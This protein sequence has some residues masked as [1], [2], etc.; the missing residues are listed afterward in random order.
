MDIYVLRK[1]VIRKVRVRKMDHTYDDFW[2]K[3]DMENMAYLFEYCDK[4]CKQL[5]RTTIDKEKFLNKFMRS[6][7]RKEME[8][9][10]PKLLSQSAIDFV[11]DYIEVDCDGDVKQF[12]CAPKQCKKYIHNQMYW[13]GWMYAYLHHKEN[14]PFEDLVELLTIKDMLDYYYFGHELDLE[15]FRY[16][17]SNHFTEYHNKRG[18]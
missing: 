3:S 8:A 10:H 6:D 16:N 12:K 11:E 15:T 14:I 17:I 9:G 7:I 18:Y 1:G 4:Y 13:I 2:L 5:F